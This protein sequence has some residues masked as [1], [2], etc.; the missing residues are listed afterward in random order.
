[1]TGKPPHHQCSA[2]PGQCH[3]EIAAS[4]RPS[5]RPRTRRC[6]R[7]SRHRLKRA[8]R[9]SMQSHCQ[10]VNI[11]SVK[12]RRPADSAIKFGIARG[13]L[14]MKVFGSTTTASDG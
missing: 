6:P 11:G 1:M 2:P 4:S 14:Q 9:R 13:S 3:Y 10:R 7:T 12:A 5:R 8:Q